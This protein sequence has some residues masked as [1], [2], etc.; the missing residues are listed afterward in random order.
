MPVTIIAN[1][2]DLLEVGVSID[3]AAQR[4]SQM[5]LEIETS[6][7]TASR[8]DLLLALDRKVQVLGTSLHDVIRRSIRY[9]VPIEAPDRESRPFEERRQ[10][11]V[12]PHFIVDLDRLRP[13]QFRYVLGVVHHYAPGQHARRAQSALEYDA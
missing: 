6:L 12:C 2:S 4:E 8:L 10:L 5:I 11:C 7:T 1:E 3:E 9:D 13:L